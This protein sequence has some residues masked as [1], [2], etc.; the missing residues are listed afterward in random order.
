MTLTYQQVL[1]H[2][3]LN[4]NTLKFVSFGLS[5]TVVISYYDV[6]WPF[7]TKWGKNGLFELS[8]A[9]RQRDIRLL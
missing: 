1:R 5:D 7:K 9:T 2:W 6:I 8:K 3:N 4:L